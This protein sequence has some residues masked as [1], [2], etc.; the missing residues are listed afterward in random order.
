MLHS[1]R[2]FLYL[3]DD[4]M[5]L[6]TVGSIL[7]LCELKGKLCSLGHVKKGFTISFTTRRTCD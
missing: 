3:L 5:E 1:L 7:V 2:Q 6:N 4:K